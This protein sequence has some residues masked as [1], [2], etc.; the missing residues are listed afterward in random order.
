M[1]TSSPHLV[2]SVF[3]EYE[4]DLQTLIA[5]VSTRLNKDA[6]QQKGGQC[7]PGPGMVVIWLR[8]RWLTHM[9]C[10]TARPIIQMHDELCSDA[11]SASSK[12]PTRL[13]VD[14]LPSPGHIT[15]LATDITSLLLL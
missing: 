6:R 11:S 12:R 9:H 14:C 8:T 1:A 4:T 13:Q 3:S 7:R 15:R 10:C 5:S 2:D